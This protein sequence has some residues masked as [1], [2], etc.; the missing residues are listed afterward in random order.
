MHG[1]S[2]CLTDSIAQVLRDWYAEKHAVVFEKSAILLYPRAAEV[3]PLWLLLEN[4]VATQ[5]KAHSFFS[6][7]WSN[8]PI[9][10][11]I[12]WQ[13]K[14]SCCEYIMPDALSLQNT[15]SKCYLPFSF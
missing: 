13:G 1:H 3:T 7:H 10:T 4:H 12:A 9:G 8:S 6:N 15:R 2:S 11:C 5:L 14:L